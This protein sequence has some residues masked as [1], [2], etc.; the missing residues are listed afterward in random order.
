MSKFKDQLLDEEQTFWDIA[1]RQVTIAED[2]QEYTSVMQEY[3]SHFWNSQNWVDVEYQLG[4]FWNDY[5]SKFLEMNR[6]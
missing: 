5:Q 2:V 1:Y 6:S 4:E 3:H